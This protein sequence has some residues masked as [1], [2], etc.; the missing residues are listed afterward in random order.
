MPRAW[1]TYDSTYGGAVVD[2]DPL[3]P[4][5]CTEP[6]DTGPGWTVCLT[7]AQ[8]ETELAAR[9]RGQ[10]PSDAPTTTSTS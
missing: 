1:P 3:P 8:L 6:A 7:D 5:G 2:T 4:N 9:D 10:S